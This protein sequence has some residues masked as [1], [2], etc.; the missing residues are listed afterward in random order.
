MV[1]AVLDEKIT[2]TK[3]AYYNLLEYDEVS[4]REFLGTTIFSANMQFSRV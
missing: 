4:M 2:Q 3:K 1:A